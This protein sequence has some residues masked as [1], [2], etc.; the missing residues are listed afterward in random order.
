VVVAIEVLYFKSKKHF[1]ISSRMIMYFS[2]TPSREK[3]AKLLAGH[4]AWGAFPKSIVRQIWLQV[5]SLL[6]T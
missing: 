4:S 1:S 2:W 6:S 5:Q 3:C